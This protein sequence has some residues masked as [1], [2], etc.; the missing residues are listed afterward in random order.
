M[1]ITN[2]IVVIIII[3]II[4]SMIIFICFGSSRVDPGAFVSNLKGFTMAQ[5]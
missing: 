4:K 5:K 1:I 3:I 2:Y